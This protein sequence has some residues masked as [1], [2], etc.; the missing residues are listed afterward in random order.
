VTE[1]WDRWADCPNCGYRTKVS[2]ASGIEVKSGVNFPCIQCGAPLHLEDQEPEGDPKVGVIPPA[3]PAQHLA[4]R[5]GGPG[6]SVSEPTIGLISIENVAM[7]D[8]HDATNGAIPDEMIEG[9]KIGVR[10]TVEALEGMGLVPRGAIG[11]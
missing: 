5:P 11:R 10:A 4:V 2:V 3:M 6:G 8:A 7:S 9:V 1:D